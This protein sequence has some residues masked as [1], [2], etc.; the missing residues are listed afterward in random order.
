MERAVVFFLSFLLASCGQGVDESKGGLNFNGVIEFDGIKNNTEPT[1]DRL[2]NNGDVYD[3]VAKNTNKA[4]KGGNSFL[5]SCQPGFTK[6]G[7]SCIDIQNN[8]LNC[9]MCHF[10]CLA[11]EICKIGKCVKTPLVPCKVP[12]K[13]QAQYCTANC[14]TQCGFIQCVIEPELWKGKEP[15]GCWGDKDGDGVTPAQG[16][17]N[18][19]DNTVGFCQAK[20]L[21]WGV[22]NP[23]PFCNPL[24]VMLE[25]A[26]P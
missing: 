22:T 20:K 21:V 2:G 3:N 5:L 12:L 10:Q 14:Y 17:C 9:G 4:L 16:D 1:G 13:E 25:T 24:Q 19:N 11:G 8:Y 7:G 15:A 23:P 6:C 18:D 26:S